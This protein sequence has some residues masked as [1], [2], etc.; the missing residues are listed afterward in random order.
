MEK[1]KL[2]YLLSSFFIF[3]MGT[4]TSVCYEMGKH[5]LENIDWGFVF[6]SNIPLMMI[7]GF[8]LF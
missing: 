5:G 2:I 3:W 7:A 6:T 1:Q 4:A 8:L